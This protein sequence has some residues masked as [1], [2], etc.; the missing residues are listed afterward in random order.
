MA[1]QRYERPI[2]TDAALALLASNHPMKAYD[3]IQAE[4][5]SKDD[6]G[7]CRFR[8]SKVVACCVAAAF[9]SIGGVGCST[10]AACPPGKAR[11]TQAIVAGTAIESFL[12]LGLEDKR[13]IVAM[14]DGEWPTGSLC[15]GVLV[16]SNWILTG[17]HC[18]AMTNPVV[19]IPQD[20]EVAIRAMV[21]NRVPHPTLDV[22][23]VAIEPG[24]PTAGNAPVRPFGVGL[25]TQGVDWVGQRV[26][27]AGYGITE[28]R[29][30]DG[31]RYA[32][33]TVFELNA[34]KIRVDGFGRSGACEGDSGGPLLVRGDDGCPRVAGVLSSGSASC[35]NRDSYIRADLIAEWVTSVAGNEPETQVGCGAITAEGWCQHGKALRCVDGLLLV[36]KCI[37][38]E[39][40]GWDQANRRYGCIAASK[41]PCRGVGSSGACSEHA[42]LTCHAGKLTIT[43]CG[44]CGSCIYASEN[45]APKCSEDS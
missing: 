45:G 8:R 24:A 35:V 43:E 4:E 17:S 12:G 21:V 40:C 18:L 1:T 30:F 10:E 2:E 16:R 36:D 13:A 38:E 11:S 15:T 22:A 6:A 42:A 5:A 31:L 27:L 14:R 34:V 7:H 9:V 33:E 25:D 29:A 41:D 28:S 44:P 26:E 39:V 3:F 32:V 37:A 20:P 23:L 19:D